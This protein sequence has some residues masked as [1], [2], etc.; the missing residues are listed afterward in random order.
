MPDN[1]DV[2]SAIG[3]IIF[4]VGIFIWAFSIGAFIRNFRLIFLRLLRGGGKWGGEAYCAHC[5]DGEQYHSARAELFVYKSYGANCRRQA[6]SGEGKSVQPPARKHERRDRRTEKYKAKSGIHA[7]LG[8]VDRAEKVYAHSGL[9]YR[10]EVFGRQRARLR[11]PL[12]EKDCLYP[13]DRAG[14]GSYRV[15]NY[16][17]AFAERGKRVGGGGNAFGKN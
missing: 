11:R 5:G 4:C 7:C 15:G 6:G 8:A 14:D 2:F 10:L 3:N 17:A 1:L 16:H 9:A 12:R 13:A